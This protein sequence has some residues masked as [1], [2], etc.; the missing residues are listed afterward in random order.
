MFRH[1]RLPTP[2]PARANECGAESQPLTLTPA[3]SLVGTNRL[4]C[5]WFSHAPRPCLTTPY[6][7]SCRHRYRIRYAATDNSTELTRG[8]EAGYVDDQGDTDAGDDAPDY[9]TPGD[10]FNE[11]YDVVPAQPSGA[12]PGA[13][14]PLNLS[15]CC[16]LLFS[17]PLT[18]LNVD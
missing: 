7:C 9:A 17:D 3:P 8:N 4:R 12:R 14:T 5:R 10:D 1:T 6:G 18:P 2:P 11:D 13:C 16:A 15:T